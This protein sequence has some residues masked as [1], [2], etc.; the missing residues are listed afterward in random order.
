MSDI[1]KYT[2]PGAFIGEWSGRIGGAVGGNAVGGIPGGMVGEEVGGHIGRKGGE[3]LDKVAIQQGKALDKS[4]KDNLA[5]GLKEY[6][7]IQLA[8]FENNF[9]SAF[10][11]P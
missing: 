3:M 1:S 6:D 7:A 8:L 10:D 4:Y 2:G 9:E 5:A 11:L